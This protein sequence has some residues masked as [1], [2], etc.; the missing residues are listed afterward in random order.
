MLVCAHVHASVCVHACV[1]KHSVHKYRVYVCM[2]V[3]TYALFM[4]A[5]VMYVYKYC[6][7]VLHTCMHS[8]AYA[9]T[10]WSLHIYGLLQ[11]S[12]KLKNVL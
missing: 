8:V 11:W 5:C 12:R 10:Q 9:Q 6:M 7:S 2:C 4:H 1:Y 3:C